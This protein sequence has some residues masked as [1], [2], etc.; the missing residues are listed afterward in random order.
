MEISSYKHY[1]LKATQ[2]YNRKQTL[3]KKTFP[4]IYMQDQKEVRRFFKRI[5]LATTTTHHAFPAESLAG[6]RE[7]ARCPR[8]VTLVLDR[9]QQHL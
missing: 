7:R 9:T 5:P 3:K 1:L 6:K 4:L 8:P 2:S